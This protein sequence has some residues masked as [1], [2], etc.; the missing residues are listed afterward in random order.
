MTRLKRENQ[1]IEFSERSDIHMMEKDDQLIIQS[2]GTTNSTIN[3]N[4]SGSEMSK[5]LQPGELWSLSLK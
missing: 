2:I 4:Q 3:V 5:E 1:T